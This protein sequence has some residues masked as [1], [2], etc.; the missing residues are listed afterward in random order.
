MDVLTPEV[1]TSDAVRR[2]PLAGGWSLWDTFMV[3]GAGLPTARW[4]PV[5]SGLGVDASEAAYAAALA[6][7]RQALRTAAQRP[8]FREALT[9]QNRRAA[10][11]GL[12]AW[13]ASP[14]E[15]DDARSRKRERMVLSYLQRYTAKNDTIGFFGPVGWGRLQPGAPAG[16]EAL[17]GPD[18]L[19]A[20]TVYV[21][22]WAVGALIDRWVAD[23][24][25][26]SAMPWVLHPCLWLRGD[27]LFGVPGTRSLDGGRPLPAS[28]AA[29]LRAFRRPASL[30]RADAVLTD[31]WRQ[32]GWLVPAIAP[33]WS[34][35]P[36]PAVRRAV[37]RWPEGP[38]RQRALDDLHWLDGHRQAADRAAGDPDRVAEALTRLETEFEARTGTSAH[39]GAGQTYAGRTLLYEDTRRALDLTVGDALLARLRGPLPLLLAAA[40]W[41]TWEAAA[42]LDAAIDAAAEAVI[43]RR[44]D[45][46]GLPDFVD[47]LAPAVGGADPLGLSSLTAELQA[48][49]CEALALTP[50]GGVCR[51]SAEDVGAALASAF[52]APGPGFPGARHHSVDLLVGRG[53]PE[54]A[55]LVLG[56]IHP[57]IHPYSTLTTREQHPC[58][59]VLEAA[60]AA[61]LPTPG[62]LFAQADSFCRSSHDA[63]LAPAWWHVMADPRCASW[64]PA[65]RRLRLGDLELRRGPDGWWAARR[66]GALLFPVARL[67]ER[68]LRLAAAQGFQL[69][70]DAERWPRVMLDGLVVSRETWRVAPASLAPFLTERGGALYRALRTWGDDLGLPERVF[71][72]CPEEPK[73]VL[74]DRGS[75]LSTAMFAALARRAS[76]LTLSEMLPD[77][78]DAALPD[79]D[80]ATYT[81]EFRLCAVDPQSFQE[82]PHV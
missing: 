30:G 2:V 56:E 10:E 21:E 6:D 25:M 76:A 35:R 53:A 14:P 71:V 61:D 13:L 23:P 68:R 28:D 78:K 81:G 32:A 43:A 51:R 41:Y 17:P 69:V 20:R 12:A 80:G 15:R 19:E 52:D 18:L 4:L 1:S 73:P 5:P 40:R 75:L 63:R 42:R 54:T 74:Y 58:P 66:G 37:Q 45:R 27:R 77:L 59:E 60:F 72:R 50:G 31:R 47:A 79:A 16:V 22:P 36:I 29:A 8:D 70:P 65:S 34:A 82:A 48:G 38:A 44:G 55:L 24:E 67:F 49:W 7:E 33:P 64:R 62:A 39:R 57:G 26:A 46:P 3:R 11:T 9:W